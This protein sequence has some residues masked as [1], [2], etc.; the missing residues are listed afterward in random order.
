M[1]HNAFLLP[2]PQRAV[3]EI[4]V[5]PSPRSIVNGEFTFSP[6][7]V[8]FTT[9]KTAQTTIRRLIKFFVNANPIALPGIFVSA[10]RG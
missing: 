2:R 1:V 4:P 7:P 10:L 8:F 6:K 3:V 5:R 9:N